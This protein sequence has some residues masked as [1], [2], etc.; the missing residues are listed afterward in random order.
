MG[1]IEERQHQVHLPRGIPGVG[2]DP[3]DLLNQGFLD[4]LPPVRC[5]SFRA[6]VR[7]GERCVDTNEYHSELKSKASQEPR[8]GTPL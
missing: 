7:Q 4:L 6:V 1:R 3:L 2:D 5:I 8:Q